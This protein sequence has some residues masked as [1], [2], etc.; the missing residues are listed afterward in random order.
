MNTISLAPNAKH[1]RSSAAGESTHG[2]AP[3]VKPRTAQCRWRNHAQ[4]RATGETTQVLV[5]QKIEI[6]IYSD[7]YEN[8]LFRNLSGAAPKSVRSP[9]TGPKV[10]Q[11]SPSAVRV[12]LRTVLFHPEVARQS[13][14]SPWSRTVR[15]GV[16]LSRKP[17]RPMAVIPRRAL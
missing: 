15:V 2:G 11:G 12:R 5:F 4:C 13:E 9:R 16:F 3:L 14:K 7:P 17:A 8:K 1:A 10:F 6:A